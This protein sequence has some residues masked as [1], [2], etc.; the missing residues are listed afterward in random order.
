MHP[1]PERAVRALT[2]ELTN[3]SEQVQ[4]AIGGPISELWGVVLAV[5]GRMYYSASSE[6]TPAKLGVPN[7]TLFDGRSRYDLWQ[8]A[9]EKI[10]DILGD[11]EARYRTGYNVDEL[12][13]AVHNFFK[14][15]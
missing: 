3:Y 15:P 7:S 10:L 5:S 4:H 8:A 1:S 13:P 2:A 6:G 14:R 11:P 12:A 9:L